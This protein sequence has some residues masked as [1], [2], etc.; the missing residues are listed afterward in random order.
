MYC[1]GIGVVDG[2][3]AAAVAER[4]AFSVG[5]SLGET[6]SRQLAVRARRPAS[7]IGD[8]EGICAPGVLFGV[9][10]AAWQLKIPVAVRPFLARLRRFVSCIADQEM[11]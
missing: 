7:A 4:T 8:F 1:P 2:A 3:V 10:R 11:V 9:K 5:R 6:T